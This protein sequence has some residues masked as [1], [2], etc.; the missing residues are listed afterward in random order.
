MREVAELLAA[1]VGVGIA[2]GASA[3]GRVLPDS[4][5]FDCNRPGQK[6]E[7]MMLAARARRACIISCAPRRP[8]KCVERGTRM[9]HSPDME[10]VLTICPPSPWL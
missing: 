6:A 1:F 10:A 8:W 5:M 7:Q 4:A 9:R 2:G 3:A